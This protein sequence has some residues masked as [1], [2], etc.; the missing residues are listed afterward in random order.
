VRGFARDL[1]DAVS[2]VSNGLVDPL[3]L[4]KLVHS[5]PRRAYSRYPV[6]SPDAVLAAVDAFV[7]K[8]GG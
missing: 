8:A 5:I 3:R 6:I 7:G 4:G 1:E 2:F